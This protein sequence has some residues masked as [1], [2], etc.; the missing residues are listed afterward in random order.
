MA[1]RRLK[2]AAFL[3]L[4]SVVFVLLQV[5]LLPR[6]ISFSPGMR[7]LNGL[8]NRTH[9]PQDSDYDNRAGLEALL[10]PGDD[11][12]RWSEESAA[13]VEGFVLAVRDGSV[14]SANC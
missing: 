12:A 2:T 10:Q 4:L 3:L 9:L 13:R 8:K 11:R 1:S 14:E 6:G 7:A 5:N